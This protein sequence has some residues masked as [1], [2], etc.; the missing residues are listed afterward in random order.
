MKIILTDNNYL[1]IILGWCVGYIGTVH[2]HYS[3]ALLSRCFPRDCVLCLA[4]AAFTYFWTTTTHG[5]I[6]NLG[7][8]FEQTYPF[9]SR[10]FRLYG[11]K[12][13]WPHLKDIPQQVIVSQMCIHARAEYL[14]ESIVLTQLGPAVEGQLLHAYLDG[15]LRNGTILQQ[16]Q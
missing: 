2:T 16:N 6:I 11:V 8:E 9:Q 3:T 7:C 14:P 15:L 4:T 5:S 13:G 12:G 1:H 10:C